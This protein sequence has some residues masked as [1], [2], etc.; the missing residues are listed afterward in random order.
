MRN[1]ISDKTLLEAVQERGI[2]GAKEFTTRCTG[3]TTATALHYISEVMSKA[4]EYEG[5]PVVVYT[6]DSEVYAACKKVVIKLGF[7][8]FTF[9]NN[10]YGGGYVKY[11]PFEGT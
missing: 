6:S 11:C 9:D 7:I 8:G 1:I 3:K 10:L 5:E 2:V 4:S